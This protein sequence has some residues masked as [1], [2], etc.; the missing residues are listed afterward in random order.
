MANW[1]LP[2]K[3]ATLILAAVLLT[4][5]GAKAVANHPGSVNAFDSIAADSLLTTQK[6]IEDA[7]TKVGTNATVRAALNK[8]I[9]LYN[10]TETAYKN[11]HTLAAAGG[12]PDP[13]ALQTAITQ[14]VGSVAQLVTQM[15]GAPAK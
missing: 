8:V 7:K 15:K 3:I 1:R 9:A 10:T 14:L 6:T 5:C 13:V 2:N 11:Y 12:N 4:G